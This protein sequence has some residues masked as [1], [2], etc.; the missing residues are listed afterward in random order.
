MWASIPH[1]RAVE[2]TKAIA[3]AYPDLY[4]YDPTAV[5]VALWRAGHDC[6]AVHSSDDGWRFVHVGDF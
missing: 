3:A 6:E 2:A 4:R 1:Y 5:P